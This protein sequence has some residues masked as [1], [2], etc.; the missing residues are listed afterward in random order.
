LKTPKT[1][2]LLIGFALGLIIDIFYDSLGVHASACVFTA[3]IR[4]LLLQLI[5]PRGGY[6]INVSPTKFHFGTRWFLLY[7]GIALFLHL[8]FYFS[9]EV[10]TFV[11]FL[12]I[13][14][15][16]IFSFIFS[17][18]TVLLY[19]FLLNPKD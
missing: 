6:P 11:Y 1:V 3:F 14:L 9:I 18:L 7:S 10:F 2:L 4:P 8:L 17:F 16:T 19:I 5:E 12:E 13:W 15:K